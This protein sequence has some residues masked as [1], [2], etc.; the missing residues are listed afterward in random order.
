MDVSWE[1]FGIQTD[2]F[3]KVE[4]LMFLKRGVN[5]QDEINFVTSLR[6]LEN[7][8]WSEMFGMWEGTELANHIDFQDLEYMILKEQSQGLQRH[9]VE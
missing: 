8:S 2:S 5:A 6:P 4:S 1:R 9:L 7:F 3:A